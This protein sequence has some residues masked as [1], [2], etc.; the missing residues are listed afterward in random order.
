MEIIILSIISYDIWFYISHILLH[1]KLY[2]IHNKHHLP[3]KLTFFV[4]YEGDILES[5]IQ[6]IGMFI[7]FIFYSINIK[8]FIIILCI[9][10]IRGMLRHE[11]NKYVVY[12]IGNHHLL[13]HKYPNYNY[14][15]YWLDYIF[16]TLY[17]NQNEYQRGLLY[18]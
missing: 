15:E 7:P 2:F 5:F 4:A 9:L 11:S 6:C 17:P 10:N 14:G 1:K 18:W 13:H 8:I 3:A 12:I 16:G